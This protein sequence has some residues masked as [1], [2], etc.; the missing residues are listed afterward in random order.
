MNPME[1]REFIAQMAQFSSLEQMTNM[2]RTLEK[3]A[4]ADKFSAVNYVGKTVGFTKEAE[5]P[6]E[7][8]KQ[9]VAAVKAVWFDDPKQ[10]P[11]LETTEGF[12]PL[13]KIEGVGPEY[14]VKAK[15]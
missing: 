14:K 5:T 6:G 11:V 7:K 12:V 13:S 9:V 15:P 4:E 2:S 10:G 8:P 1:D 3:M